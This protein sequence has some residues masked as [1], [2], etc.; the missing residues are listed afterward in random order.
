[1]RTDRLPIWGRSFLAL[2]AV[3][4][5]TA[6]HGTTQFGVI[7]NNSPITPAEISYNEV[8]AG[9][10]QS[11]ASFDQL[12]IRTYVRVAWRETDADGNT[13]E[14]REAGDGKILFVPMRDIVLTVEKAGK[15]YLW[16]GSNDERYWL[17]DLVDSSEKVAYVGTYAAGGAGDP[18]SLP[19]PIRPDSVPNLLGLVAIDLYAGD[20]PPEVL[21][22]EGQYLIEPP[23]LGLRMLLDPNSFRPTRVDLIDAEGWSVVT[24]LLEGRYPVEVEG[25]PA[26]RL[27]VICDRAEIYVAGQATRLSLESTFAT[28]DSDR[29]NDR[30]F[31]W[32]TLLRAHDPEVVI[33]LDQPRSR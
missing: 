26:N 14:R 24:C 10:N 9:Y 3:L 28:T 23:G 31:D 20:D 16:A 32:D 18:R 8:I 13:S 17:F 19:I 6:C 27:P 2:A 29:I 7:G 25:I 12:F 21:M 11:V 5:L 4:S 1:L 22:Y 15:V 33:D 30:I